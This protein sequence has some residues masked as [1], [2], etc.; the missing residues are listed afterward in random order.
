[1]PDP[2]FANRTVWTDDNLDI[3]RGIARLRRRR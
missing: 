2:N 1:M 3:L